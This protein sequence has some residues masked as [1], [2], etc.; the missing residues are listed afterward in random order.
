M[1]RLGKKLTKSKSIALFKSKGRSTGLASRISQVLD[2][3][4]T[5]P[6]DPSLHLPAKDVSPSSFDWRRPLLN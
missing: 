6:D 4:E 3:P 2:V 1:K 5:T